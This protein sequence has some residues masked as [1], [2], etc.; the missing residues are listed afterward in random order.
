LDITTPLFH[1]HVPISEEPDPPRKAFFL[2]NLNLLEDFTLKILAKP[3]YSAPSR[4]LSNQKV[5]YGGDGSNIVIHKAFHKLSI[6]RLQTFLS[7]S[8]T[9]KVENR[10]MLEEG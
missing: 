6:L 2:L 10:R 7:T 8:P 9:H 4:E 1:C 3:S 5:I